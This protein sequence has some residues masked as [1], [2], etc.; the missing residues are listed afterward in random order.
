MQFRVCSLLLLALFSCQLALAQNR[1]F[2]LKLK[3]LSLEISAKEG[4]KLSLRL[5]SPKASEA[6]VFVVSDPLRL[7]IDLPGVNLGKVPLK[8]LSNFPIIS[9]MRIGSHP[10]KTRLV[11]DLKTAGEP[12]F[13]QEVKGEELTIVLDSLQPS[14]SPTA[15]P[16]ATATKIAATSPLATT[17]PPALATP[18]PTQISAQLPTTSPSHLPSASPT[19]IVPSVTPSF[20]ATPSPT[21]T[22]TSTALPSPTFSA[23]P[24]ASPSI[25]L[26]LRAAPFASPALS[27]TA[28]TT[29]NEISLDGINFDLLPEHVPVVKISLS[30]SSQFNLT[31]QDETHFQLS[32]PSCRLKSD[33]LKLP[34]FPPQD[35]AGLNLVQ[36]SSDGK[37]VKIQFEVERGFKLGAVTHLQEI[38][39]RT[40]PK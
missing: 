31:R 28:I 4:S 24:S 30:A 16:S 23:K 5:K 9:A 15:L 33:S 29:S 1:S 11:F 26:K 6:S 10:D 19:Q 36:A 38:W 13:T 35:F 2:N 21:Q 32:I 27:V 25:A 14:P 8:A 18:L 20:T 22:P 3:D 7:A 39:I 40:A 12:H 17:S 34:N 37:N